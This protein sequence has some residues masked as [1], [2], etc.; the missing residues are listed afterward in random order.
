MFR[1][2]RME[3]ITDRKV[4]C[5]FLIK[6]VDRDWNSKPNVSVSKAVFICCDR[7]KNSLKASTYMLSDVASASAVEKIYTNKG[8]EK[9][10]SY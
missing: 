9:T 4:H 2:F 7:Y 3:K 1:S 8:F 6:N 5:K 10:S